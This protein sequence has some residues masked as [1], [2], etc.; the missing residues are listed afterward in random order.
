MT[1][2]QARSTRFLPRAAALAAALMLSLP[3]ASAQ[4][5]ARG[6]L[7]FSDTN[8]APQSCASSGCHNGF[9]TARINGIGKGTSASVIQAAIANN[10]G[11]MG[12]LSGY[13]SAQDAAD[14]AA[15]IANPNVVVTAPAATLSATAIAFGNQVV[16][17]A[18]ATQTLTVGNTGNAAL[19]ITG[20]TFGGAHSGDFAQTGGTCNAGTSVA[21]GASCTVQLTFTPAAAGAR[22]ATLTVAH[23]AGSG[24]S[25]LTL[26]GTG[27]S[28]T[29]VAGASPTALGFAQTLGTTSTPQAVTLSNGGGAPLALTS[30][31]L[32]GAQAIDF[33]LA[34][35]TTCAAGSSVAAG[36]SCVIYVV[37][38]PSANGS[39]AATL[40]IAHN[41]A[42]S[43]TTIALS[44]TGSG[45]PL[46]AVTVGPAALSFGAQSI[47]TGSAAQSVTVTNSG[48]ATLNL[49]S[50]NL[51]GGAASD[52]V[53]NGSCNAG[54]ALAPGTSCAVT[55][56]FT[57]SAAGTR[58]ATLA[59]ASDAANG[60]AQIA[61][62]GSGVQS[63]LAV[64]P[65]AAS[66]QAEVGGTSAPQVGSVRNA[67]S[68]VLTVTAV[69]VTGT[70]SLAN[71]SG[72]C[73]AAPFELAAGQQ[74]NLYVVFEPQAAG[75]ATG[76]V[77]ITSS[78]PESPTRIAL[79]AQASAAASD[80]GAGASNIGFGGCSAG[81]PNQAFDPLLMTMLAVT[82]LVLLRRQRR[83]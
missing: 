53:R 52:F 67:G 3:D 65:Q 25:A 61:L 80:T 39:R 33:D 82:A 59:I 2:F 83:N 8:G 22:S 44:G 27:V 57:P 6:K 21:A 58:T 77:V 69:T 43:P 31:T 55:I 14:I 76:E 28:A 45:T 32:T 18:S 49:A 66:F 13:V 40:S 30:I 5:A 20:L 12:I 38:T 63:T 19:S 64:S 10:K 11:G 7:L 17:T 1:R 42:G 50:L 70:F 37:F 54:S 47:G 36:A 48:Q 62:S 4:D 23:N 81:D 73:A 68:S 9:P 72:A 24:S 46:P 75:A 71:G 16:G 56:A 74:C 35:G 41:A 51:T 60:A 78:A 15:Y 34:S 79:S 26:S 29:P